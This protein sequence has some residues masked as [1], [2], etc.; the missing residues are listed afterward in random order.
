MSDLKGINPISYAGPITVSTDPRERMKAHGLD[1]PTVPCA[2]CSADVSAKFYPA[3]F[4]G[5]VTADMAAEHK[6]D[7]P[8][9]AANAAAK[10]AGAEGRSRQRPRRTANKRRPRGATVR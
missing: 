8:W 2:H 3:D 1:N 9:L 7:C 6:A 10:G 4:D 5:S